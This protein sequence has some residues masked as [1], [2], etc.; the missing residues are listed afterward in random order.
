ME[1]GVDSEYNVLMGLLLYHQLGPGFLES[2][3]E[4]LENPHPH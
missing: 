4:F 2:H 1:V 3:V